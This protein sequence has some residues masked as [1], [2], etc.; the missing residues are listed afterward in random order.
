MHHTN[1]RENGRRRRSHR[2]GG[3]QVALGLTTLLCG[4]VGTACAQRIGVTL[5]GDPVVFQGVGPQQVQGRVLVPVRGVLEKLGVNIAWIPQNQTVVASNAKMDI[6]LKI[7]DTRAIVNGN[8][9]RL[10]VPAQIIGGSTMVP[11]RFLGEALGAEVGWNGQTQTVQIVT[12]GGANVPSGNNANSG[13]HRR[14]D[15]Q[16]QGDP[17]INRIAHNGD[18]WLNA[19]SRLQVT[20]EGTPGAQAAFRIPG[21]ADSVPM[22][23]TA[24]G[25]Y[26]G[27]WQAPQ[28][29][30]VHL[31]SAA[32]IGSLKMGS[33]QAPLLQSAQTLAIDADPPRVRDFSPEP[34][35]QAASPRPNIYAVFEDQGSGVDRNSVRLMVNGKDVTANANVTKD[36]V[37]YTP[38]TPL[39]P[40]PQTVE[41]ILADRAGNSTRRAWKFVETAR[42]NVLLSDIKVNAPNQLA[43]GDIVHVEATGSP[44]SRAAFA[45]GSAIKNVRMTEDRPGHY[46]GQYTVRK[47]D[48]AANVRPRVYLLTQDGQ[49]HAL[50]ASNALTITTGKP[51]K[52]TITFPVKTDTVTSPLV[53]KGRGTPNTKVRIKVDYQNRVLGVLALQGTA[54]D[55]IVD[56]DKNGNW[57]TE[58]I[59]LSGL[60][61]NRN[62]DYTI[63]ATSVSAANEASD[64]V[65]MQFRAR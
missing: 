27:E 15:H 24:P 28:D 43:P 45:V 11:L 60:F 18:K 40:G 22:R 29:K 4:S 7:G 21:V 52:P 64:P 31:S 56:V 25:R 14:D 6:Q 19:G 65:Q 35:T 3:W 46:V 41:I 37:S 36:F 44:G 57:Q 17:V 61:S 48:D 39:P 49:R 30:P 33:R 62:V 1:S 16:S 51:I 38:D 34:D 12:R 10:D 54:A 59:P 32:V 2:T 9:V 20:M 63:T 26:V 5:N 47:G 50:D 13:D 58:P 53:V 42:Q 23:E 8:P 55:T